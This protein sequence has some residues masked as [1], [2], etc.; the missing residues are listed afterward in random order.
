MAAAHSSAAIVAR[1]RHDM[2]EPHRAPEL[3]AEGAAV[4]RDAEDLLRVRVHFAHGAA[5]AERVQ[6]AQRRQDVRIGGRHDQLDERVPSARILGRQAAADRSAPVRAPAQATA[7]AA[8]VPQRRGL[9]GGERP[10]AQAR[11]PTR[12]GKGN[13]G[14][15]FL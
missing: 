2:A 5:A 10:D 3:V 7:R 14:N 12:K 1:R 4:E 11:L 15:G 8:R 9:G 13:K 6:D